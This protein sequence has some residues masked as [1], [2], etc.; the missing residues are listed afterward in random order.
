MKKS[1]G[2]FVISTH[3]GGAEKSLLETL[4][5]MKSMEDI[6]IEVVLPKANGPLVDALR[7]NGI[8]TQT[9]L[10]PEKILLLSRNHPWQTA[11][12]LL[13]AAPVSYT[14]LTLP[15]KA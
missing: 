15:T 14:H 13:P 12:N 8:A 10:M 6:S 1:L 11:F 3:L 2:F 4:I 7:E 5:Y 9:I